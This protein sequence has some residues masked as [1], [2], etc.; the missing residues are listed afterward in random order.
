MSTWHKKKN[1]PECSGGG[2]EKYTDTCTTRTGAILLLDIQL[3]RR[4][5][6]Y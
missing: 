4:V 2:L 3:W 5:M 1:P 6:K